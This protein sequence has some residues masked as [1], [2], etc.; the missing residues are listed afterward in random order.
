MAFG[1]G[2]RMK[3]AGELVFLNR[4]KRNYTSLVMVV[5]I[6]VL[7][8]IIS[9]KPE[10]QP[11]GSYLNLAKEVKYTGRESCQSCHQKIYDSFLET[12]MG[13]SF[14]LPDPTKTIESFGPES[15]VYD[16]PSDFYYRPFWTGNEFWV[17]EFRLKG[18]DTVHVRREKVDYIVGS[19]HQTRSY[20]MNRDGRLYE[21]PITWYVARQKWDLSPGYEGGHNTRFDREIGEE[22]MACHTGHIQYDDRTTN[23]FTA[24]SLGIDCEK[25]HG[26]GQVHIDR[27][28][29]DEIVDVGEEIDWSIVNPAKLGVKEQFDVCQQCHLQGVVVAEEGKSVL[30]FRP[31]MSLPSVFNIFI[32]QYDDDQAFGIASHAERLIQS[33]CFQQSGEKLT[34]TTCHDPHKSIA[35]TDSMVYVRQ[36]QQC[37]KPGETMVCAAPGE[38]QAV[39]NGNCITCHMPRGGTSDIPHVTFTDHRIRVVRD[40]SGVGNVRNF[41]RLVCMTDSSPSSEVIG[42]A[43]LLYFERQNPKAEWLAEAMKHLPTTAHDARAK[44]HF[45]QQD[46]QKALPEVE[47]ALAKQPG[48]SWLLFLKAEILEMMGRLQDAIVIYQD[49]Y[50]RYPQIT[51]AGLK[52]GVL[53]L[54]SPSDPQKALATAGEIF[55]GLLEK[56]PRDERILAN[57]GFVEMNAGKLPQAIGRFRIAIGLNPDYLL[58]WENLFFAQVQKKDIAGA[59]ASLAE[60]IRIDP[61]YSRKAMLEQMLK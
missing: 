3:L 25:C 19:G 21:M 53:T 38:Q 41:L 59:K 1:W 23:R 47:Q 11:V 55:E 5:V 49:I 58:A 51:E 54:K 43:W 22:C 17:E 44:A 28:Q 13:K 56:H 42:R 33:K 14:Y 8:I 16:A 31:G 36:C 2:F 46:P 57:L 26:P 30:D 12:G 40:T 60:I 37:H 24:I 29:R 7:G 15:I 32:E 10:S 9:C 27:M 4:M 34:C 35:I 6:M 20:I 39:A 61:N 45:F 52:V 48:D 18:K 50:Q